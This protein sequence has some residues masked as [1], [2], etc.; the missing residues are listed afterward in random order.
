MESLSL[1]LLEF[2]QD[3]VGNQEEYAEEKA[4]SDHYPL[5]SRGECVGL[6]RVVSLLVKWGC[7]R[8]L[9]YHRRDASLTQRSPSCL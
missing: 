5:L 4:H 1:Q 9:L 8:G 6:Q 2:S 7:P 3:H